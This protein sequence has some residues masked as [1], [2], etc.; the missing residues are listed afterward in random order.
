MIFSFDCSKRKYGIFAIL[1]LHRSRSIVEAMVKWKKKKVVWVVS[2]SFDASHPP[3]DRLCG[4][5][6]AACGQC[7]KDSLNVSQ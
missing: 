1:H 3:L 5:V 7:P 4:F 6:L 2:P